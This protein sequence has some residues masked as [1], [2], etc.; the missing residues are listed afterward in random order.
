[1]LDYGPTPEYGPT[2]RVFA[3]VKYVFPDTQ[4]GS[5]MPDSSAIEIWGR[6]TVEVGKKRFFLE[7][8]A[9]HLSASTQ[10]L[11]VI[12]LRKSC[13]MVGSLPVLCHGI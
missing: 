9:G 1:M 12:C 10:V 3:H 11:I 8:S 6:G 13:E 5:P 4:F 2:G 7:I